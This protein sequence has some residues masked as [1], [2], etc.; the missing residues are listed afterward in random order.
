MSSQAPYIPEIDSTPTQ[1]SSSAL[2]LTRPSVFTSIISSSRP[3][4]ILVVRD[5]C[6]R[7][8]LYYNSKYNLYK[9]LNEHL[10][11][12]YS[13]YA[14]GEPLHDNLIP[15][16]LTLPTQH[17]LAGALKRRRTS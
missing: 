6:H 7:L 14:W 1:A 17:T 5:L 3:A 12:S 4:T 15:F 10:D 8:T 16:T 2:V 9:L 13:L 11:P